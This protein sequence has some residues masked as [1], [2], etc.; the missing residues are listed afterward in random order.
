MNNSTKESLSRKFAEAIN[1]ESVENYSN[2]PDYILGDYLVSCLE[3][4]NNTIMARNSWYGSSRYP[5]DPMEPK[6]D[7]YY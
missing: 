5:I 3:S 4:F 6:I 7:D 2:T 1:S